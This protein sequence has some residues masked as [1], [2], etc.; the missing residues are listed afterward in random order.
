M[1]LIVVRCS[2]SGDSEDTEPR[3]GVVIADDSAE[4]ERLCRT[5]YGR[6]GFDGFKADAVVEGTFDGPSRVIGYTGQKGAFHWNK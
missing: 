3:A 5:A 4:A 1:K 2:R 6:E